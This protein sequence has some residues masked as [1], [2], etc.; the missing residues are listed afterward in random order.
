MRDAGKASLDTFKEIEEQL[1]QLI[2]YYDK[3]GLETDQLELAFERAKTTGDI[4]DFLSEKAILDNIVASK[5]AVNAQENYR[6]GGKNMATAGT[7][8]HSTL[9]NTYTKTFKT[10]ISLADDKKAID[11]LKD[12]DLNI[13]N[14]N[15]A[16][17][18]NTINLDNAKEMI[19]YYEKLQKARDEMSKS[20]TSDERSESEVY[21]DV[22][23]ELNALEESYTIAKAAAN[24]VNQ[25][26]AYSVDTGQYESINKI[27]G[28]GIT[29]IADYKDKHDQLIETLIA[30]EGITEEEAEAVLR[31][32]DATEEWAKAQS[33]FKTMAEDAAFEAGDKEK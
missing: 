17:G 8:S 19:S 13:G 12:N 11:I 9:T 31:L 20:M 32:S 18:Q 15:T 23:Q 22:I 21:Q 16:A 25:A 26:I 27:L 24:E 5:N 33:A 4:S 6:N 1:P 30:E 3:L 10:G 2:D 14:P 28:D 7:G 29:S